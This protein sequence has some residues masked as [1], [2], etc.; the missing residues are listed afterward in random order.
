L[1]T[2]S[3][4]KK[5]LR[6][7]D[8]SGAKS[9]LEQSWYEL[10][11][12]EVDFYRTLMYRMDLH[13]QATIPA[14]AKILASNHPSTPDP[15]LMT[16]LVP[17]Q[18]SI[19]ILD[20]LFKIPVIG[21]SLRLSGHIRVSEGN[22]KQAIADGLQAL[23]AGRTVGIYPEGVISPRGCGLH[24]AHTG[25]ARLAIASGVP[26]IPIGVALDPDL[27]H[28]Y[29]SRVDGRLEHSQWC[30][31]GPYA[32]TIGRPIYFNGDVEDRAYVRQVTDQIMKHITALTYESARRVTIA[33]S[34]QV[35]FARWYE[36]FNLRKLLVNG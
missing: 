12:V 28:T 1:F 22:G 11:R 29:Q 4:V 15:L 31:F 32:V 5:G 30:L 13:L 24:Q 3:L 36:L 23:R 21:H 26:V 19:L 20:T 25:V 27:I 9:V 18:V 10:G 33:N 2:H 14:G 17:E 6:F 7:L 35:G 16:T 34:R 8:W